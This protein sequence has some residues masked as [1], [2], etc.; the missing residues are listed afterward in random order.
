MVSFPLCGRTRILTGCLPAEMQFSGYIGD[1]LDSRTLPGELSRALSIHQENAAAFD[2]LERYYLGDQPILHRDKGDRMVNNRVVVNY[3]QAFTRDIVGYTYAKGI[4]Y[5]AED[6]VFTGDVQI[7]NRM[8]RSEYKDAVL[9]TLA[10]HQSIGGIA[11]LGILPDAIEKND[12]PFELVPLHPRST[13]VVYS[14]YNQNAPVFAWT[15]YEA[16][17]DGETCYVYQVW[18]RRRAYTF[19]ARSEGSVKAE[20]LVSDTPHILGEIPIIAYPNNEFLLGDWECAVS[21]MDAMNSVSSDSVND[22]EQT[23]LSY[24]VLM[25]VD[26]D[27]DGLKWAKKNRILSLPPTQGSAVDAKFISA[28]LDG[29]GVQLLRTYLEQALKFV[30]GIPD[31]DVGQGGSDTGAGAEVRTGSGD[32]EIVA[33]NKAKFTEMAERRLLRIALWLLSPRYVS[34]EL[35]PW[36][37]GVEIPR[38]KMANAQSKAQTGQILHNMGLAPADIVQVMDL[39]TDYAGTVKRWVENLKSQA[40]QAPDETILVEEGS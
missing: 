35:K 31:R 8:M 27:E 6:P 17:K 20:D 15:S 37:I 28:Q 13:E 34:P 4:Q 19:R 3:A 18:T 1:T 14:A 29:N 16:R 11:Y 12:V 21:L 30:V 10:D 22:V 24:L 25:G 5:V 26:V 9:K 2:W 23:I 38:N 33:R 7:I 39:S 36:N 40:A 32:L